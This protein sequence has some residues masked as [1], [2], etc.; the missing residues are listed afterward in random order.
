MAITHHCGLQSRH[1]TMAARIAA[2]RLGQSAFAVGDD[3]LARVVRRLGLAACASATS[4]SVA[5]VSASRMA[6][7]WATVRSEVLGR[8]AADF[9]RVLHGLAAHAGSFRLL[10]LERLQFSQR[11]LSRGFD[12]RSAGPSAVANSFLLLAPRDV[13]GQSGEW[14]RVRPRGR[15]TRASE[16]PC[17]PKRVCVQRY[18]MPLRCFASA[19]QRVCRVARAAPRSVRR[20]PRQ[21]ARHIAFSASACADRRYRARWAATA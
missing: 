4:R 9:V 11:G 1:A 5:L 8:R 19:R 7:A 17:P 2:L 20:L 15:L 6:R 3:L 14:A 10:A 16:I 18:A 21:R 13:L 12:A